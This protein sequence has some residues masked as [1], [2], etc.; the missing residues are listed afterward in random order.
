MT[1]DITPDSNESAVS[2]LV[3]TAVVNISNAGF[4]FTGR[5]S[6]DLTDWY[7]LHHH[8]NSLCH[9]FHVGDSIGEPGSIWK[10]LNSALLRVST[11]Q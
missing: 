11:V 6:V 8:L 7:V 10:Q 9:V 3:D 4:E 2:V 1:V 5:S